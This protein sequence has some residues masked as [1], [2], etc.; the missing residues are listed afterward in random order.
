[1][2]LGLALSILIALTAVS[3]GIARADGLI[4]RAAAQPAPFIA[5]CDRE[6]PPPRVRACI[7][8][9]VLAMSRH[10]W[11]TSRSHYRRRARRTDGERR[12]GA[13][14]SVRHHLRSNASRR[15]QVPA[16]GTWRSQSDAQRAH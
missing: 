10:A 15:A 14:W 13:W 3:I 2:T 12:A 9:H 16:R 6:A 8:V 11:R 7:N 4:E 5:I 1:A